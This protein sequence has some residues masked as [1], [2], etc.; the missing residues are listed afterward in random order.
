MPKRG[1]VLPWRLTYVWDNGVSGKTALY[2]R[3]DAEAKAAA[4]Q[5][6][7]WQRGRK[8]ETTVTLRKSRPARTSPA[9]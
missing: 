5:E 2:S 4:M 7:A 1:A 3:E 6:L 8:V 9:R